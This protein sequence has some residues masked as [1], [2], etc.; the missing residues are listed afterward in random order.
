MSLKSEREARVAA[1]EAAKAAKAAAELARIHANPIYA[2]IAP[3]RA[4]S[5]E[6]AV[7][8]TRE[9]LQAFAARFPVGGDFKA[10]APAPSS[11]KDSRTQYRTK[12]AFRGLASRVVLVK[13]GP[14]PE[15]TETVLGVN[16]EGIERLVAEAAEEA[17]A[18]FDAYVAKLTLK[19]GACDKAEVLGALWQA[20]VL[21]VTKGEQVER[22]STQQ[23][24]NFSVYGKAFNQ[25]PTRLA[26]AR[27]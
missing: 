13:N 1:R 10:L 2:A 16:E 6:Q 19:V 14:W 22:W 25:W 3:Q 20:S 26:K 17:A 23:I 11:F 7:N 24:I 12:Q 4:D 21:T 15:Y 27:K 9:Q 5:I 8:F 18:S